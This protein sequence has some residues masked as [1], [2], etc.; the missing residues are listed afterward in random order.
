MHGTIPSRIEQ[1]REIERRL[2]QGDDKIVAPP[3]WTEFARLCWPLKT[4]AHLAALAGDKTTERTAQ[5]WLSG[6]FDPPNTVMAALIAKLF[7]RR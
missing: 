5:R 6:E 1:A 7:E 3:I 2:R 4:A